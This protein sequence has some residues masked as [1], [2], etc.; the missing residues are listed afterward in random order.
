MTPRELRT[1]RLSLRRWR[2]SDVGPF[3][4][5]NADPEVMR[6]FPAPLDLAGTREMVA[7]IETHHEERGF[8]L[9]AVEVVASERGP[10]P[11]IGFVGLSVP[12]FDPP[13][14]AA[15]PC[16]EVGWRLARRWWG[17]GIA[18]EAAAEALRHAFD[19]L[20][21]EEVVSFTVPPN[22][23]SQAVMQRLGMRYDGV[24]DH[25]LAPPGAWWAPHVLYRRTGD[26]HRAATDP[27]GRTSP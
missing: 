9:W 24:F 2:E 27:S 20:G 25:P 1:P 6:W 15:V 22:L 7:R 26:D 4:A 5:L 13:F 8:G 14:A 11:F 16:V 21:L 12:R 18:T 23:A 3:A 19:E 10:A 17:L